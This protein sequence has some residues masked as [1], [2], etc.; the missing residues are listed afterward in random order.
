MTYATHSKAPKAN[1]ISLFFILVI[2]VIVIL[3]LVVSMTG[4][5]F[6]RES[7]RPAPIV[8]ATAEAQKPL[9]NNLPLDL[10][11]ST[12]KVDVREKKVRKKEK[13]AVVVPKAVEV[14][15]EARLK[16]PRI[17]VDTIIKDMG[18]TSD[19]AMA[20][21]DNRVDVGWFSLGTR[22][23]EVGSA[24]IGG[25]NRFDSEA[26]VF[27]DLDQLEKGDILSVVDAEGIS[28]SFVVRDMRTY[29][30]TDANT[31]IF[32]SESGVHLNL[33]TCSGSWDP[34]TKSSTERLVI[35]TDVYQDAKAIAMIPT[36]T[37]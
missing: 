26:G 34:L 22:P 31:G 23:G 3:L 35:F 25:H 27:V 15:P 12:V 30:A 2:S 16:I 37:P 19:G 24:V 13:V 1:F 11:K 10:S 5:G 33:I 28:I 36:K 18:V 14:L 7:F 32:E 4:Y 9:P 20:V 17:G 21:P 8:F 6:F 29:D